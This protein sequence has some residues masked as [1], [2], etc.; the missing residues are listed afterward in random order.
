MWRRKNPPHVTDHRG[1]NTIDDFPLV[2][3]QPT[4]IVKLVGLDHP[5][6]PV[7]RAKRPEEE[8]ARLQSIAAQASPAPASLAPAA[9]PTNP[10][11]ASV[12]QS[13]SLD[14]KPSS[15]PQLSED[16]K[17]F[18]GKLS[19]RQLHEIHCTICEHPFRGMIEEEFLH[20]ISPDDISETFDVGWRSI[21]RHAHATGLYEKRFRNLRSALGHVVECS[22]RVL[23]GPRDLIRA[24]HHLA[25]INAKGDWTEPTKRVVLSTDRSGDPDRIDIPSERSEPRGAPKSR[26]KTPKTRKRVSRKTR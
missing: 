6:H 14:P 24:V 12:Q 3:E 9:P 4:D 17:Q 8:K 7:N 13:Q 10:P 23:P 26:L 5:D 25:R 16:D 22:N 15:P 19:A 20:W 1:R 11:I 18:F 2:P 21:Y